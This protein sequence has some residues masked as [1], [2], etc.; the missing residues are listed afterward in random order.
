MPCIAV[1]EEK[2]MKTRAEGILGIGPSHDPKYPSI[3]SLLKKNG[4][5][6][7]QVLSFALHKQGEHSS[8]IFGDP[9]L[10]LVSSA[11]VNVTMPMSY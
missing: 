2:D 7:R 3:L 4:L 11:S 6:D 5:I 9:D 10:S 1:E 8:I